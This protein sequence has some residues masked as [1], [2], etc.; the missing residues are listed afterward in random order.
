MAAAKSA[1]VESHDEYLAN[2]RDDQ[3][4]AL[5]KLRSA[6]KSAA[7]RAEEFISYG[8]PAFRLNGRALVALGAAATHCSFF[9]MSGTT[10]QSHQKE[11]RA[12]ETS[13]G[14][15]RFDPKK[16]LPTTLVRKLV[17][18]RIAENEAQ[19]QPRQ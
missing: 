4:A 19:R 16:P 14:T 11:L 6:I 13:K 1:K 2:L 7:P 12:Y 8:L 17:K 10:V 5:E 3:R 18:A 15:I 9:P